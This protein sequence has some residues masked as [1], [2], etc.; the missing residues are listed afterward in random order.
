MTL[1]TLLDGKALA[2]EVRAEIALRAAHFRERHGRAAGLSVVLVGDD[3]GSLVYTRSKEKAAREAGFDGHLH[4]LGGAT[5]E[6]EL[7]AVVKRLNADPLVDGILVQMPLPGGIRSEAVLEAI[8]PAKDVD[9]FHPHNVGRLATG[10]P[11][12]VPCTPLGCLR[13]IEK[14]G[15]TLPGVRA[16]VVGRS[17]LV[18][19]PMA[20]LLLANDA[21]VSVAHRQTRD[22]PGLCRQA[23]VLV[24]AAGQAGLVRGDWVA[25]GAVVIDVGINRNADGKLVGDVAFDEV[26]GHARAI[27]PVPGG[28]GPMTIAMLLDNTLRAAE[29]RLLASLTG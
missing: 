27:T 3:A 19:R 1:A 23:E 5:T 21:T 11:W 6:A 8:D 20:Q 7:L 13:L 10:R 17:T 12:L 18:G 25:P 22:L 14:A 2:T 4:H 9:G 28:V 24:V 29:T 15:V 16:V 26:V